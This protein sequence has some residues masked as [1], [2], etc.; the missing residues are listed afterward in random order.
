MTILNDDH[1][2]PHICVN[3][4]KTGELLSQCFNF[5]DY[6]GGKACITAENIEKFLAMRGIVKSDNL[7]EMLKNQKAREAYQ[8]VTESS[9]LAGED[10]Q[11]D[12]V[13]LK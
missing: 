13:E 5:I 11:L 9:H 2:E 4:L 3:D 8:F 12:A 10:F 7:K 6:L 1:T